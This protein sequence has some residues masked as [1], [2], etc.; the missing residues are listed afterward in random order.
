[1]RKSHNLSSGKHVRA[2]NTPL[3]PT[4]YSKTGVCRGITIFLNF[5]PKHRLWAEVVLRCSFEQQY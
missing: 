4:L 3:N 5:D 2:M 1:M